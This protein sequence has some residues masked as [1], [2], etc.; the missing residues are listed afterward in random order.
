MG[1]VPDDMELDRLLAERDHLRIKFCIPRDSGVQDVSLI[2][3]LERS[4][5]KLVQD[6]ARHK[7]E[8]KG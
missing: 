5:A 4:L 1:K 7:L 8:I 3:G 2:N 6:V